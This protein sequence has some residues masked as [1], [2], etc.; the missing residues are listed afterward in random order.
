MKI[1][2]ITF[3]LFLIAYLF[4]CSGEPTQTGG[5]S[6]GAAKVLADD[7]QITSDPNDQTQ[8]NVA[9]DTVNKRYLVVWTD[10]RNVNTSCS[11]TALCGT[12]IFGK[13]CTG[14][15]TGTDTTMTCGS[16]FLI[17]NITGGPVPGNQSQPKVAFNSQNQNYLVVWTDSR[18]GANGQIFGQLMT[19]DGTF[20]GDNFAISTITAGVDINQFEPDVIYDAVTN[21][22]VVAWVDVTVADTNNQMVLRGGGCFNTQNVTFIPL[23][24]ADN[25]MVRTAE[26]SPTGAVSNRKN[27]SALLATDPVHDTGTNSFTG[28]WSVQFNEAKPKLI[29][30]SITGDYFVGWSG[31]NHSVTFNMDYIPGA[32]GNV[33][34][35]FNGTGSVPNP[36]PPPANLPAWRA[37]DTATISG[38][39]TTIVAA[40]ATKS[41]GTA[42][43]G[44]TFTGFGTTSLKITINAVSN[45]IGDTNPLTIT[46]TY[47][48]PNV[49]EYKVQTF[50]STDKD[51]GLPKV[52]FRK[53]SGLGLFQDFS[54]GTNATALALSTDPNTNRALIAWEENT[55]TGKDIL[56][57]LVD[58]NNF[59]SYGNGITISNAPGD[60]SSPAVSY[61]NANQRFL[62]VWEDARNQ[63]ANISNIDI[64]SQFVD[65]QGNLSGANAPVTVAPGNQLAPALAF[66][67]V[68]FRKFLVVWADGRQPSNADIFGQLM[69]FSLSSQLLIEDGAGNPIFNS[70]I[71]FGN[72]PIGLTG[73]VLNSTTLPFKICNNGN[74]QLTI[75]SMSQ[76]DAPFS[77]TT[78]IP[79]TISPGVC[80]DMAVQFAPIAAGS[81]AGNSSNN[82]KTTIDSSGGKVTLYFSGSGTG[83][84]T[85]RVLTTSLPDGD[86]LTAYNQPLLG[87]GGVFPFTWSVS[88]GTLP[89]GMTIDSTSGRISGQP[90]ASGSFTFT[91]RVTDNG[92]HTAT[93]ELTINVSVLTITNINT[94]LKQ[95]TVGQ[96]YG[97]PP[98][99]QI[100]AAGGAAP[101]TWSI[102]GG[103]LPNGLS[104]DPSTGRIFGVPSQSGQ[105][106]FT[107]KVTESGGQIATKSFMISINSAPSIQTTSLPAGRSGIEYQQTLKEVGGTPTITW[108]IGSGS[109]PPGLSIDTAT[110]I[111]SGTPTSESKNSFTITATDAAGASVSKDLA[112]EVTAAGA[113]GGGAASNSGGGCSI[114]RKQNGPTQVAD[115]LVMLAPLFAIIALRNFRR[116]KK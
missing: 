80:S 66:G 30:S 75:N 101:Y 92:G 79:V 70:A 45:V 12:D 93:R 68:D 82:F 35:V 2:R 65:P 37:T 55:A 99:E 19:K 71:D 59:V 43:T 98:V 29:Y 76:P 14:S 32:L 105:F 85:L 49:C 67:D 74:T 102:S 112:I 27:A 22:F 51:A 110:G 10:Y 44:L 11:G 25:N 103:N 8:P 50:T 28:T 18:S 20:S 114:G 97:T 26:V 90:T 39:V 116:K 56:G 89:P 15:G 88:A 16:E 34:K 109:L 108:A 40:T 72:F 58:L 106:L 87:F 38:A 107:V 111:I 78:P 52:K 53:G 24:Q 5:A 6:R 13:F 4:G 33:F 77:I 48:F 46:V 41:D 84:Q 95:W 62:V 9:Y 61:D 54:F 17:S 100:T 60:Q 47:D 91:V 94:T 23:P 7:L 57:Q 21:N 64:F 1:M 83:T 36:A 63:S 42:A 81:F 115:A 96:E 104:I 73:G 86:T 3:C 31:M 69:E 113:G